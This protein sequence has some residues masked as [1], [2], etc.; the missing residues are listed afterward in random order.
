MQ[1]LSMDWS[2]VPHL[3]H[4]NRLDASYER[5]HGSCRQNEPVG[6]IAVCR[7][8]S[9]R[10]LGTDVGRLGRLARHVSQS[11]VDNDRWQRV[12]GGRNHRLAATCLVLK[13]RGSSSFP[14]K[15]R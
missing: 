12:D 9:S 8:L 5:S 11:L 13:P 7:N 4:D 10:A 1:I 14:I 2:P 15:D 3:R 6:S